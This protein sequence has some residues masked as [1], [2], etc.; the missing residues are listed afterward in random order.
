MGGGGGYKMRGIFHGNWLFAD[1]HI[2]FL[3][4][5][6]WVKVFAPQLCLLTLDVMQ[7]TF[8]LILLLPWIT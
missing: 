2:V 5:K 6:F 7:V 8:L 1:Q 3:L 4:G